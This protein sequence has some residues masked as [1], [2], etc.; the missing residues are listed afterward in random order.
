MAMVVKEML[1]IGKRTLEGAGIYDAKVDAESLLCHM[2]KIDRHGLFM[3]WSKTMDDSQ[4]DIF[5]E[6]IDR[7]ASRIPLQHIVGHQEFMGLTFKVAENVLIPRMDTE[8]LV[9]AVLDAEEALG[10]KKLSVL[11]LCSGSGA[12]G[13]SL[14]KLSKGMKVTC[15]DISDDAIALTKANAKELKAN[16]TVKQGNMFEPFA[17]KIL[18]TKFDFIVSNPPY[19]ESEVIPTLEREVTEHEPLLALD[20]GQDGL[21]FYRLIAEKAKTHLNKGG[22][23]FLEIGHNQGQALTDILTEQG[24]S[25]VEVRKDFAGLDR[26]VICKA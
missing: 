26:V 12:I 4:C 21:D 14:A 20:G 22:M 5:F 8:V 23:L 6:L 7:R 19:I 1:E 17:G 25:D 15:S 18:K 11:D 9:Q 10:G 3:L 16:I 2:L 13:V 24:Y